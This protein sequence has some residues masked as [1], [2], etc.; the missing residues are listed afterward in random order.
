MK[1]IKNIFKSLKQSKSNKVS[2]LLW[3]SHILE[4]NIFKIQN[5]GKRKTFKMEGNFFINFRTKTV[6][7]TICNFI[8][9]VS[10]VFEPYMPST[11]AKINY[12]L[13]CDKDERNPTF[14]KILNENI[15]N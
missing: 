5:S 13:G 1:D 11:S 3:K 6:I 4:T 7:A 10:L 12:L 2:K 15:L 9:L 14:A 8:R